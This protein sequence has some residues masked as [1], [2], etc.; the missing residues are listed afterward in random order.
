[1]YRL[2]YRNFGDHEALVVCGTVGT[3]NSLGRA[4]MVGPEWWEIRNPNGTPTIFQSGIYNPNQNNWRWVC[5]MGMDKNGNIAMGYSVLN[6]GFASIGVTGRQ[7]ADAAGT[8][9]AETITTAG[10]GSQT[11]ENR[12]G[13]YTSMSI[14]PTDD[15]TFFYT[16]EYYSVTS[17]SG[18]QTRI[19]SFKLAP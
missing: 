19:A 7:K 3:N 14:D 18:W 2:A 10:N 6:G 8:M 9:R 13:D 16:N 11:G 15:L 5:S 17:A 4:T 1:M 12:W